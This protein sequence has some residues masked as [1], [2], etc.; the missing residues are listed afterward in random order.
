MT[1]K[2]TNFEL[3][4]SFSRAL[5]ELSV[6]RTTTKVAYNTVKTIKSATAA[7]ESFE[8]ARKSIIETRCEMDGGKPKTE[9]VEQSNGQKTIEYVFS[10]P[11][12]KAEAIK[13]ITE[14]S[15]QETTLEVYPVK[16]EDFGSA[17]LSAQTLLG[18]R[19]FVIEN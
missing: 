15:A 6:M 4:N 19:D 9:E 3:A 17:E 7:I 10:T 18:L 13:M 12:L 16:L 2:I 14:L 5:T 8:S 1:M 11:E